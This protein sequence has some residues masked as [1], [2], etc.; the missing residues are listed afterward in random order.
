MNLAK[1]NEVIKASPAIQIQ[2][3][4]TLLQRRAWNVLLANA[5]DEL[6]DKDIHHVSVAELAAKLGF[7]SGN[8]EHLKETLEALGSCQ[9]KRCASCAPKKLEKRNLKTSPQ[10][11]RSNAIT[12]FAK[13]STPIPNSLKKPLKKYNPT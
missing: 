12:S 4:I 1:R 9:V 11:S 13:P 6:P 10:N 7:N 5:Y 8:R 3:R 2:S